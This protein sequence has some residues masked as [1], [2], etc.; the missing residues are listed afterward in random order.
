MSLSSTHTNRMMQWLHVHSYRS[1][2]HSTFKYIIQ[3]LISSWDGEVAITMAGAQK[4]PK[5]LRRGQV[6]RLS[7]LRFIHERDQ[8]P[9][10][11]I[12]LLSQIFR[13]HALRLRTRSIAMTAMC[14]FMWV[15]LLKWLI[16]CD[17]FGIGLSLSLL[18][19][20][21]DFHSS[22]GLKYLLWIRHR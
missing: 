3:I 13:R 10:V 16:D 1:F 9:R 20:L 17:C 4:H 11:L 21:L 2:T 15:L 7:T 8:V 12:H 6:Y 14:N 18:T 19:R 22:Q 5:V